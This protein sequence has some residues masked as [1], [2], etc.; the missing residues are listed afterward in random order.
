MGPPLSLR[1]LSLL[2]LSWRTLLS[3][4]AFLS[5]AYCFASQVTAGVRLENVLRQ[6]Y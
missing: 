5:I 4:A 1:Q 2:I 6:R 3:L